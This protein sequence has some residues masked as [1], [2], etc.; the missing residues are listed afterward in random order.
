M[1]CPYRVESGRLWANSLTAAPLLFIRNIRKLCRNKSVAIGHLYFWQRLR[2]HDVTFLNNSA[3]G[4]D[5]RCEGIN[6]IWTERATLIA[7]HSAADVVPDRGG[8][9]PI[10][11]NGSGGLNRRERFQI[12]LGADQP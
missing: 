11:S 5:E 3:L 12:D 6:L 8:I 2:V 4:E 9:G 10:G 7:R 1:L